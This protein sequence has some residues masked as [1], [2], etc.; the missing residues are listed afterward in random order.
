MGGQITL[1]AVV[2]YHKFKAGAIEVDDSEHPI[3][4]RRLVDRARE[5]KYEVVTRHVADGA[6]R[7][8]AIVRIHQGSGGL[9]T[10]VLALINETEVDHLRAEVQRLH[11][12]NQ[13]LRDE[14][15]QLREKLDAVRTAVE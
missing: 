15:Q 4:W 12:E 10:H 13:Q 11:D 7:G 5:G 2:K 6:Y 14:N 3:R 9:P 8:Y 1:V